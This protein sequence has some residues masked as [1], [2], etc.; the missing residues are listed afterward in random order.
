MSDSQPPPENQDRRSF[1]KQAAC[2]G[3]GAGLGLIPVG[4]GLGV[5]FD[6]VHRS[7]GK[8]GKGLAIRVT[9]LNALP[10][11]G[12]P[13]KFPVV[14]EKVDAWNK[15]IAPVGAVY[16][17]RTGEKQVEALNVVCPHAGCFVD[18]AADKN[19]YLC[20]CHDSLFS[21]N[22]AVQNPNSPS[23]RGMDTLVV[24]IREETEIWV[25]FQNFRAGTH[26]KIP[27]S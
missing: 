15:S 16:L 19:A 3:L 1:C 8:G 4:A 20:P 26:E 13:R 14:A 12:V 10:N 24:E 5:L 21:L 2:I 11:D 23:P 9:T 6:P 25:V 22:G 18:Y 17:R 7:D 27:V